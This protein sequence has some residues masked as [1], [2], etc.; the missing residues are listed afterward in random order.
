MGEMTL[1]GASDPG[2]DRPGRVGSPQIAVLER[3][4]CYHSALLQVFHATK[5]TAFGGK[6]TLGGRLHLI[7]EAID[8]GDLDR[9]RS[10][11]LEQSFYYQYALL[12]VFY[13]RESS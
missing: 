7:L 3:S 10:S 9:P 13:T 2:S 4:F 11:F 1:G 5:L 6:L 12:K 8:P